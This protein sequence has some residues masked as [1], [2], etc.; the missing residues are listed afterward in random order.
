MMSSKKS[1]PRDV[2]HLYSAYLRDREAV[3]PD[4]RDFF[5]G[6][7]IPVK[8]SASRDG[9]AAGSVRLAEVAARQDRV[10]QLVRAYR[11]R[12]HMA[13]ELDPLGRSRPVVPELEP[14]H[15]GLTPADLDQ[16]FS[17]RTIAGGDVRT[18]R[19][20]LQRLRDT[21]CR[22][23]G[24]Q[25]MHIDDLRI[26]HWLQERMEGTG[27]RIQLS[28]SEQLRILT[29]LTEA[30]LFEEFVQNK[31]VGVK[32]FSLEGSES[33]IPLLATTIERAAEH[34]VTDIVLGM[35]HRGRLNVLINILNKRPQDIFREFEE[36]RTVEAMA[37]GD[38]KYHLGYSTDWECASGQRVHL[39]LCFN[40]S[41]LEFINPV[42]LGRVRARQ[43]RTGD[44]RR[45]RSMGL[46]I[47]GDASFAAQGV[48]QESLN[49]SMVNAYRTGGT[50]HV[51]V[52]NQIGFTT[53]PSEG[54]SSVYASAV[55]KMLEIPIFHV[56]GEEP[57]AVAQ[58]V[59]LALDFR[60]EF[61]RDVVIDMYGYRRHGHNEGD[62]P[63]FTQPLLYRAI[64]DRKSVREGYFENLAKLRGISREEADNIAAMC[65]AE[66]DR[67]LSVARSEEYSPI[68]PDRGVWADYFGGPEPADEPTTAVPRDRLAPLLKSI[69]QLPAGFRLHPRLGRMIQARLEMAEA[70]R[71]LDWSAGEALAFATLA[72]EG[73]PIRLAGQDTARGTFSQRHALFHD[74][75]TGV[76][77]SPFQH[78]SSDQA[79]VEVYN[80]PLSEAG[81]VGF[82]Y[83]YS[84]D[85]PQGLVMWEA[86]FGDFCNAAQVYIDQFIASAE[87]KW[88]RLSGLVLLLP[89]GFEGQGPEHSSARLE[90]FLELA[91][92]DNIQVIN[93]TTPAQ[94]FHCLRRQA[95][96][97]WRKPLVV[98]TP[99]S[100][101]RHPRAGS[102][103]EHF[104]AGGFQQI[105]RDEIP[106]EGVRRVLLCSG[107][108]Y[109]D[110]LV[111]REEAGR[112]DC[113]IL[114]VEQLYPLP[115]FVLRSAMSLFRSGTQAVW[116]QEEPENMGA[117]PYLRGRFGRDLPG[118]FP[119]ASVSRPPS[120]SPA[121][122]S[123]AAHK[124][125][126]QQL[127][128]RAFD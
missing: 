11:V 5:D 122:G 126:Q 113:A 13:A 83:G 106:A 89:H 29:L 27:N 114:R 95:L 85:R 22:S 65:Q 119:L 36:G 79:S 30:T 127:V 98:M 100:L 82:E 15:Y 61:G 115:E 1:T 19:E 24:V 33:L 81:V 69:V 101:L 32:T 117:W 116:V 90:R 34:G 35:A 8:K 76:A 46:L 104:E 55:A 17:S 56:N 42:V 70:Q 25:F 54:R 48:V 57:E 77:Y 3:A 38:V 91:V 78:L 6:M 2:E 52:N 99:K 110:L 108:V 7:R 64:R 123:T 84:L 4:W 94:Y 28:R 74:V 102:P 66:L 49:L 105:I 10:D 124:I 62:E 51:I 31:Y 45:S 50:L 43:D 71:P 111:H 20:I 103:I 75:E 93:L 60:A 16:T 21:Y 107:K 26:R 58:V 73:V 68:E 120:A 118:G 23:I 97:K 41:H 53:S 96:R 14:E 125:Q 37:R 88:G 112:S 67:G 87:E 80:S 47:H 86:Q 40:P 59:H 39:S 92:G 72:M 128:A 9:D 44:A 109:Y 121:T 18:L 12:G 63:A